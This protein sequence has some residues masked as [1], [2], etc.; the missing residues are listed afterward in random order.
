M[1]RAFAT[2]ESAESTVLAIAGEGPLRGALSALAVQLGIQDRVQ[3]LGLRSDVR[4]LMRAADAYVMSSAWEGTPIA[5]LEAAACELPVVAT[6]VGGNADL[7]AEGVTGTL[8]PA[9]DCQALGRAMA[10]IRTMDATERKKM[11]VKGRQLISSVHDSKSVVDRWENL[12]AHLLDAR[13]K[14]NKKGFRWLP[15]TW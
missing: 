4:E 10:W 5:L 3:I 6:N 9:G 12:Y 13:S 7:V 1:L 11:G 8:V 14:A 2:L 15:A